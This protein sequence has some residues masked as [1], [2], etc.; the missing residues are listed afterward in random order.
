MVGDVEVSMPEPGHLLF[1]N[2]EVSQ[3]LM[4]CLGDWEQNKCPVSG[5]QQIMILPL[6]MGCSST[7]HTV[8]YFPL[9][10][11]TQISSQ[12]S[13]VPSSKKPCQGQVLLWDLRTSLR[14]CLSLPLDSVFLEGRC[15][16]SFLFSQG[17][18]RQLVN[19]C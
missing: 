4:P 16:P 1:G 17:C 12:C 3:D 5:F 14:T 2:G 8:P 7:Q 6:H 13:E 9:P 11:S 10:L 18:R 19:I 15:H